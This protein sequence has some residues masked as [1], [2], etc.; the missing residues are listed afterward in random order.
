[1]RER[2]ARR[3]TIGRTNSLGRRVERRFAFAM[4]ESTIPAHRTMISTALLLVL[5]R[6]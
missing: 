5:V 1:M 4:G 6:V 3:L 2:A